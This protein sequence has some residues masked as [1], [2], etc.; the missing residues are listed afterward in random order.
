MLCFFCMLCPHLHQLSPRKPHP[1]SIQALPLQVTCPKPDPIHV[2]QEVKNLL[3]TVE[4]LDAP[5]LGA[6]LTQYSIKAPDTGNDISPP[7]PFNLMF[8]TSIGP[9]SDQ[10]GYLRPETAQGIFVNFKCGPFA[11]LQ[12]GAYSAVT[13]CLPACVC[14]ACQYRVHVPV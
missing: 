6:A 3:A 10:V 4:E 12:W 11:A 8:K 14:P 9:R 1:C 7:F 5:G 2:T 13:L